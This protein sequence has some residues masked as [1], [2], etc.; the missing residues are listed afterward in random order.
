MPAFHLAA[1]VALGL[2][3]TALALVA[4]RLPAEAETVD[5]SSYVPDDGAAPVVAEKSEPGGAHPV[6]RPERRDR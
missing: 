3:L 4:A 2:L 5:W 1:L 6:Q